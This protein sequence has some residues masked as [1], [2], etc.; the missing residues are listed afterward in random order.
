[1]EQEKKTEYELREVILIWIKNICQRLFYLFV[2]VILWFMLC[3][4]LMIYDNQRETISREI[5]LK[6]TF[7]SCVD[8]LYEMK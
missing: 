4:Y 5:H 7:D 6:P 3:C 2:W 1:M 8:L